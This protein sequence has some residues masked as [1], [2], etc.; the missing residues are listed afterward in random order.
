MK[1]PDIDIDVSTITPSSLFKCTIASKVD[2]G[3]LVKHNSG[4]YFQEVPIDPLTK[5]CAIPF[6]EAEELGYIKIDLLHIALL[7][8]ISSKDELRRLS[9]IEPDW[10]LFLDKSIVEQLIHIHDHFDIV[11]QVKP[12]SIDD[13][14]DIIALIRPGKRRL[15]RDYLRNK[16][17]TR[18]ELYTKSDDG[19]SFKKSHSISYAMLI[20]VNLNLITKNNK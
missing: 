17:E 1:K 20:V 4:V 8:E 7:D 16:K 10:N 11:S 2:N 9:K 15:L 12:T 6:K 5:L 18:K 19:Y 14:S 3:K 13:I